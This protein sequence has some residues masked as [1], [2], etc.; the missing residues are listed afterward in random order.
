M[1]LTLA[2]VAARTWSTSARSTRPRPTARRA[3]RR[4]PIGVRGAVN[5]AGGAGE[6]RRRGRAPQPTAATAAAPD[7]G[8]GSP[9]RGGG[10][11]AG[12][13][14]G[15]PPPE[16]RPRGPPPPAPPAA[17]RRTATVFRAARSSGPD[18]SPPRRGTGWSRSPTTRRPNPGH[19]T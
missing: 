15:Q 14:P 19:A 7:G 17:T 2:P 11:A 18:P 3:P 16:G 5:G 4:T 13:P 6:A 12:G 1:S 9:P 8:G 10:G